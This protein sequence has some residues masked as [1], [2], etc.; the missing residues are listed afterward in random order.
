MQD[1][2]AAEII[3]RNQNHQWEKITDAHAILR[4]ALLSQSTENGK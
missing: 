2:K 4:A 3:K 1:T